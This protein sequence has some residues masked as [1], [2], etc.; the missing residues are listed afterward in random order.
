MYVFINELSLDGKIPSRESMHEALRQLMR[1]RR[2][3]KLIAEAVMCPRG[4]ISACGFGNE[5]VRESIAFLGRDERNAVLQWIA[6]KGP[7]TDD[8]LTKVEDNVFTFSNIDVTYLG[9]GEA[10]RRTKKEIPSG[11]FSFVPGSCHNFAIT[12]LEVVHGFEGM[13]FDII[14]VPNCWDVES[15]QNVIETGPPHPKNW[16]EMFE[17]VTKRFGRLSIGSSSLRVLRRHPFS[18]SLCNNI[19]ELLNVLDT[20]R[21]CADAAGALTEEGEKIRQKYFVGKLAWFTDE[22]SDNKKKFESDM[23]FPDPVNTGQSI[24]CFWHGKIQTPQ[25]RVHFEW[26]ITGNTIKVPYIGPKISKK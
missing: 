25:F 13:I 17:Y 10:A 2:Q 7:F 21:Q 20:L 22:S 3:S 14:A 26:P 11:T 16:D 15:L 1:V 23:T 6:S 9:L 4:F 8:E 12:P 24:T 5:T 18:K 19:I